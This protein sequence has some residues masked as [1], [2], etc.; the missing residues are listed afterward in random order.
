MI[1]GRPGFNQGGLWP[2]VNPWQDYQNPWEQR[3]SQVLLINQYPKN[4]N[5][6]E[7]PFCH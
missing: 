3:V 7:K 2:E 4:N 6:I 1:C 5:E